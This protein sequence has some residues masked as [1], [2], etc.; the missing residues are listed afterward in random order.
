[1]TEIL[2]SRYL[3]VDTQAFVRHGIQLERASLKRLKE[4]ASSRMIDLVLTDVVVKEVEE[5]IQDKI[6]KSK[7]LLS[8]FLKESEIIS[9]KIPELLSTISQEI[10]NN[11]FEKK[12]T[13]LWNEY[14]QQS[15]AEIVSSDVVSTPDLL[16]KY[17][18][19]EPPFSAKKK[20]EFPDAISLL[21]LKHWANSKEDGIY[22]VS[23]D[24]DVENWCK[25][26]PEFHYLK[27]LNDFI[28]LYNKTEEK[29]TYLVHEIFKNERDWLLSHIEDDFKECDFS[30]RPD[31][32]A[33][34]EN[35]SVNDMEFHELNVI[36]VDEERA[37][38][39]LG[40]KI[41]FSADV[42]G[43]DYNSATWDSIDKEYIYIPEYSGTVEESEYF[44]VT[45]EVYMDTSEKT[46]DVPEAILF[47]DSRTIEFG[48]DDWPYK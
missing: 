48:Y 34:I 9:E 15:R 44:E 26:N 31:E 13:N 35:V 4:L 47:D 25:E 43:K 11:S 12:G 40:L 21:A 27:S 30:F 18:N 46:F 24:S 2:K 22:I 10:S 8:K 1:M 42:S 14:L 28:D 41:D 39:N 32:S 3:S 19:S 29:L 23:G 36:E 37:L 33:Y 7:I 16:S 17:F 6:E 38:I 20:N 5:K 45:I